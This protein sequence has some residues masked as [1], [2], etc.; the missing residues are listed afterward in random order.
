MRGMFGSDRSPG[1]SSRRS[2]SNNN[3][4]NHGQT[5]GGISSN[6]EQARPLA[7]SA[8]DSQSSRRRQMAFLK[9][10]SETKA[11]KS[12]SSMNRMREHAR[13]ITMQLSQ[14]GMGSPMS[15]T[16]TSSSFSFTQPAPRQ[17]TKTAFAD[18]GSA[19]PEDDDDEE[20]EDLFASMPSNR[21]QREHQHSAAAA[22]ANNHG[23]A[24]FGAAP[25][26]AAQSKSLFD[27]DPFSPAAPAPPPPRQ[28]QQYQQPQQQPMPSSRR[29]SSRREERQPSYSQPPPP[30]PPQHHH[31]PA[32][33]AAVGFETDWPASGRSTVSPPTSMATMP[34]NSSMQA[35]YATQTAPKASSTAPQEVIASPSYSSSVGGAGGTASASASGAA[36]RRRMRNQL[37]KGG[38]PRTEA[39]PVAHTPPQSPRSMKRYQSSD[40]VGSNNNNRDHVQNYSAKRQTSITM[41]GTTNRSVGSRSAG[42]SGSGSDPNQQIFDATDGGFSFDAFGLDASQYDRDV[43]DAMQE[44]SGAHPDLSLLM[45]PADDFAAGRWDSPVGSRSSTP[46]PLEEEGFVDGFRITK[47]AA[48]LP[49]QAKQSPTASTEKSSLTSGESS[50]NNNTSRLDGRNLFK[51]QA[52]F[53]GSS[54]PRKVIRP[55]EKATFNEG[56]SRNRL[57]PQRLSPQRSQASLGSNSRQHVPRMPYLEDRQP[58][59]ARKQKQQQSQD[60]EFVDAGSDFSNSASNAGRS[61]FFATETGARSDVAFSSDVGVS[62]DIGIHSGIGDVPMEVNSKKKK[63]KNRSDTSTVS[64]RAGEEKKEDEEPGLNKSVGSLRSQ[65]E[66]Q[67]AA[68]AQL[69]EQRHLERQRMP[70]SKL[71]KV[72]IDSLQNQLGHELLSPEKLQQREKYNQFRGAPIEPQHQRV[73]ECADQRTS[74]ASLKE[75]LKSPA[76]THDYSTKSEGGAAVR[77]SHAGAVLGRLRSASP[78]VESPRES[79]SDAGGSPQFMA[80]K[81]RKTGIS[82]DESPRVESPARSFHARREPEFERTID[83]RQEEQ[84]PKKMTYRERREIDLQK[85]QEQEE[86]RRQAEQKIE[87]ESQRDVA[88]LIKRRIAA[89]KRNSEL[90]RSPTKQGS[91]MA[92]QEGLRPVQASVPERPFTDETE[93][94]QLPTSRSGAPRDSDLVIEEPTVEKPVAKKSDLSGPAS[95]ISRMVMLQHIE[96]RQPKAEPAIRPPSS[97]VRDS[98]R[99]SLT[100]EPTASTDSGDH[101]SKT[102]KGSTPKATMMMLNAFLNGRESIS[103]ADGAGAVNPLEE[104]DQ[105]H[106]EIVDESPATSPALNAVKDDPQYERFFRMLKIGMPPDVV[107]HAMVRDGVDP[108]ILDGD[109]NKPASNKPIGVPLKEDP[110][111]QKYIKML[112]FGLPM[113]AVKHAMERDGLGSAVMDQDH[114]LPVPTMQSSQ[115]DD[116]PIE[117]DSHRRARLHWKPLRKVTSNSLWAKIDQEVDDIEIDE[118]EFQ[119]LFQVEKGAA[120]ATPAASAAQNKR[121]S[122]VRVIDPKRANNGGIILARLKMSHDDMADAVDRINEHALTAEQIENIIEYLPAKEERKSL[123]AYMLEGGQDAAEKFDGLCECEKF[124]VSMMT[125]KHAKRK[126]RALLFKLQFESCLED[127]HN[128][129]TAI[130]SACD[131]LS[132][133]VRL[134]QLFGFVLTFGNRLNMAG[135]GGI[136]KRKAGAFTLDSLLK[137]N[138]AKAFDKKTTFLNYLVLIVQRN[139][140]SLLNFKDDLPAVFKADKI[141]WDSCL[142]DLEEVENQLENVRKIALYQAR[143]ARH[144]QSYK[145]RKKKQK[146][147]NDDG[148]ESMSEGE[149][150]LT[151][152]EEVDHL[153]AT[154]VGLFTLSAIKYVSSL[155]DRVETTKKKFSRLLEYFGEEDKTKQPHELFNTIVRF[156]HDFDKAKETVIANQKKEEREERK[157]QAKAA[158]VADGKAAVQSPLPTEKRLKASNMQP[159][160]GSVLAEMKSRSSAPKLSATAL[161]PVKEADTGDISMS[162]RSKS[163]YTNTESDRFTLSPTRSPKVAS[164][165]NSNGGYDKP[166]AQQQSNYTNPS[167]KSPRRSSSMEPFTISV[168]APFTGGRA[169]EVERPGTVDRT[170]GAGPPQRSPTSITSAAMRHKARQRMQRN[171]RSSTSPAEL[172]SRP[173]SQAARFQRAASPARSDSVG[174]Y[175]SR[176]RAMVSPVTSEPVSQRLYSRSTVDNDDGT[177]QPISPRASVRPNRRDEMRK[178]MRQSSTNGVSPSNSNGSGGYGYEI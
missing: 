80:I 85:E 134:R 165:P 91:V 173:P 77:H 19:F 117:K 75:R 20:E 34:S 125:V 90:P 145:A 12:S 23:F 25:A 126:V 107:K 49:L 170:Y 2:S 42:S 28:H 109:P 148:N 177:A 164:N 94:R 66:Q 169:P 50:Q 21:R 131:N 151:L 36:A 29:S 47:Q 163:R 106:P 175:N 58:Q 176:Q 128:D 152:E 6:H 56:R 123:E 174:P 92:S 57:S 119:E 147:R 108:S 81:L 45:D 82:K 111:Y 100:I 26:K 15:S 68:K 1:L 132:N 140:E 141:F 144:A 114:N 76:S 97:P 39:D 74:F 149:E 70:S 137:L 112:G 35:S 62:S 87:E 102:P 9:Y 5:N 161:S 46:T 13:Q 158:K 150:S 59:F 51:E 79:Q 48:A 30:S 16:S 96:Q 8:A 154:P 89:N 40:S 32:T 167:E 103:S 83:Y 44:I 98:N 31:P 178:N 69:E 166:D 72:N 130:E 63:S 121:G 93:S 64:S 113:E 168:A 41:T 37:R 146:Q 11:K 138:Q 122:S 3:N 73:E 135:K 99:M 104:N 71:P 156:S 101:Q 43:N 127:I 84:Q 95:A 120:A 157:R 171:S 136:G 52:G 160:M 159:S 129:T 33:A 155:R 115:E 110:M 88:S 78:E 61:D 22:A 27:Q 133:S 124:M 24:D 18:F 139:N 55:Y 67:E 153:R 54:K 4:N 53:Q 10:G 7:A 162:P 143:Q 172:Q 105:D 17:P 38:T 14:D 60:I 65:W 142:A 86:R 118:E 116:E